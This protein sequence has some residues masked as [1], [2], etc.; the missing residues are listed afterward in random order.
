MLEGNRLATHFKQQPQMV[1]NSS[2]NL[3]LVKAHW[4]ML[5]GG[6][7]GSALQAASLNGRNRVG[8]AGTGSRS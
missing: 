1:T 5:K 6:A 8:I 3:S 4:S 7:F 2:V